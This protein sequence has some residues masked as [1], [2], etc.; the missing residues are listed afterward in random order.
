MKNRWLLAVASAAIC[1]EAATTLAACATDA[2]GG[3]VPSEDRNTPVPAP[4]NDGGLDGGDAAVCTGDCEFYPD[5]CTEDALCMAPLF[6]PDPSIGLD[7][8]TGLFALAARSPNDAWLSGAAGTVARF[9]GNSWKRSETGI[10]NSLYGLWLLG[11]AEIAFDDPTRLFARGL[12][13][14]ADAGVEPSTDGWAPFAADAR[15]DDVGS[16]GLPHALRR[17]EG[18]QPERLSLG[19]VLATALLP[20][21]QRVHARR[22]DA[23]QVQRLC[24][25]R[26]LRPGRALCRRGLGGRPQG[27]CVPNHRCRGRHADADGLQHADPPRAPRRLGA[28]VRRRLGRR[29]D[30]HRSSL[31]WRRALL[32][33]VRR[34]PHEA[35]SLCDRRLLAERHLDRRR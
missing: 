7:H 6:D 16:P 29:L 3:E 23:Q 28:G 10:Q 12:P 31:P 11:D 13:A 34:A 17:R 27:R 8:R 24:V 18:E 26:G 22:N 33:G 15:R 30:R 5:D 20:R 4:E 14:V 9:D 35:A 2:G 32:G 1:V 21:D 19:R 25:Q